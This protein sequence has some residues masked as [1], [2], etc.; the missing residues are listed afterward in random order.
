LTFHCEKKKL[1]WKLLN[2]ITDNIIK[3]FMWL[4]TLTKSHGTITKIVDVINRSLSQSDY[5]MWIPLYL[6]RKKC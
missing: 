3:W 1:Q 4:I 2:H 5:V 6:E